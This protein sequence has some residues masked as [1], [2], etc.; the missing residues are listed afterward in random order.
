MLQLATPADREAVNRLGQ[1]I[2]TLHVSFRPDHFCDAEEIFSQE[3]FDKEVQERNLYVAR[4]EDQVVGYTLLRIRS[5]DGPLV[6]NRRVMVIDEFCVEEMLRRHGIGTAMM[7]DIRALAR[8]FR[9]SQ[10]RL[11]VYPQN[12]EALTFYQKCGFL[13]RTIDM[14]CK[15]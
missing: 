6:V 4:L 10:L 11:N 5:Y 12:D 14:E 7:T 2:H 9:C 1:Q 3:R 15:L 8:A 13:I